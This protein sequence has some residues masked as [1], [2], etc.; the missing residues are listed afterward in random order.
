MERDG[1]FVLLETG[2]KVRITYSEKENSAVKCAVSKLAEDIRKVCDCNVEL[3][4]S[5]GN[6]VSENETE[7][8]IITM[9]TPCSLQNIPEE[10]LPAL[11]R[12]M[13]GQGK[14]RWEA[15]LHQIYGSSFY[16]VG[17]DRRGTVFGIYDLSEQLGIS[18]WYF[19]ADVP[20]RKKER[21]IFS[22]DYSK[23]DWPDVPYRG[24]FLNDEEELEAWSKLHTEDDTIGPVTYAHI[25]ELLLRLKA[26][27]I[28]PAMH[29][30]YFNGDPENLLR[31]WGL[32]WELPIVICYFAVIR[33]SGRP[34]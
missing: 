34:G 28:W 26:N 1:D 16:I 29:V 25:F 30:N 17:A 19:W 14:G 13:D 21:F 27:Y 5:F 2:K 15:Y 20:V 22:K 23:A 3:G 33:M 11:E 31:K 4:S 6:S 24:I 18:P 7:I 32:L 8:I 12:I 9:D 10:M